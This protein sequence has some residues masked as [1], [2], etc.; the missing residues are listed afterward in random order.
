MKCLLCHIIVSVLFYTYTWSPLCVYV[1]TQW[2]PEVRHYLPNV[3]L[4]L[5][6]LKSDLRNDPSTL[7]MLRERRQEPVTRSVAMAVVERI[8]AEGYFECSALLNVGLKEIFEHAVIVTKSKSE[9]RK[10]VMKIPLLKW[11]KGNISV[12]SVSILLFTCLCHVL[13]GKG[14]RKASN[15]TQEEKPTATTELKS[16]PESDLESPTVSHLFRH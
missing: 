10:A 7:E 4:I 11:F 8:G 5:V 15:D 9:K 3:P 6:G 2:C 16:Q 1:S 12:Y 14:R 13:I